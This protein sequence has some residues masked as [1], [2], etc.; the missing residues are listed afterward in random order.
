M[1]SKTDKRLLSKLIAATLMGTV[2]LS[3]YSVSAAAPAESLPL[4]EG[5]SATHESVAIGTNAQAT[6]SSNA[7]GI[8]AKASGSS[9]VLGNGAQAVAGGVAIGKEAVAGIGKEGSN[10]IIVGGVAVGQS[11][12]AALGGIA[13]GSS[14]TTKNISDVVIGSN[15]K[16][17]GAGSTIIGYGTEGN[18]S[19]VVVGT[20]SKAG[21]NAL[22]I[23]YEAEASQFAATA[24]GSQSK[25][26]AM[27]GV[28]LGS[29][30][31]ADTA[32][33]KTG[34]LANKTQ[35]A[36]VAKSVYT[37]TNGAVS[38]G[39]TN[40]ITRQ[41]TNVA[42]GTEDTDV[43]NVRQLKDLDLAVDNK[44]STQLSAVNTQLDGKLDADALQY[45]S[46]K[47]TET[48]TGSNEDNLGANGANS[49]A[50]GPKA[51]A[52]YTADVAMGLNAN[53][54]GFYSIALGRDSETT[55]SSS[56]AVGD[57]A[58][59]KTN[60][61][62]AIG[63]KAITNSIGSIS[64]GKDATTATDSMAAMA[65]GYET[66][67]TGV[68][69][70]AMGAQAKA[71]SK[72]AT[73]VGFDAV[74]Q[75]ASNGSGRTGNNAVAMG[76]SSKVDGG[77][78]GIAI[79]NNANVIDTNQATVVGTG[80]MV[81]ALP[82]NSGDSVV[83][84]DGSSGTKTITKGDDGTY[85]VVP[86]K[87]S[88][89][90][91]KQ[92]N[93]NAYGATALGSRATAHNLG[94][95]AA[96]LYA[97]AIGD[98]SVAIGN[99]SMTLADSATAVGASATATAED[100]MVLGGYTNANIDTAVALGSYAKT[101]RAA[102]EQVGYNPATN[103]ASTEDD[104][105]WKSTLGAVSVGNSTAGKTRQ[106]TNV[107]AGFA[108]TDAVN[109]AQLKN[110]SLKVTGDNLKTDATAI[111][112]VNLASQQ[113]AINGDSN[114][115][116]TVAKDGQS[117]NLAL[118]K[119]VT[120]KLGAVQYFS[121]NSTEA[122]NKDNKG[123]TKTGAIAIGA[124]AGATNWYDIAIGNNARSS[125]SW[126]IALGS[127]A[128]V[129]GT[130]ATAIGYG[131]Q[132]TNDQTIALGYMANASGQ[133]ATA[134]GRE[135][136]AAGGVSIALGTQTHANADDSV[137]IGRKSS[138][139]S[140]GV[141]SI[142]I[143]QE[144]YIGKK[145]E[146]GGTPAEGVLDHSLS[147]VDNDTSSGKE[148]Q[149][150]MNSIAIGSTA[151]SYGYQNTVLGVG[152]EAH[153]T[154]DV[155][156]GVLAKA[157]GH[158]ATA[159]GKQAN[160]NGLEATALGHWARA[161]GDNA[162]A[163]G[164]YAITSTLDGTGEVKN[165]IAIGK[166]ARV[167]SNNSVALGQNSL[168]FVPTDLKTKAYLSE[169]EFAAENGVISVG[170]AEYTVGDVSV[171]ENRR[172][173]T[174]VAGG[175]DDYDAVNVKQLKAAKVE[176]IAG[177]NVTVDTD[178]TAGYT[179]YTVNSV[180]TDTK[181]VDGTAI[182]N[183]NG[184]GAIT[185]NTEQNGTKGKVS[186]I[187]LHDKYITGASLTG[188]T[189]TINR[190]DGENFTVD[191]IATKDDVTTAVGDSSWTLG[192]AKVPSITT[193]GDSEATA[194][195][196]PTEIKNGNTVTLRAERGI[197]LSQD[198]SNIDIGLKYID[199]DPAVDAQPLGVSDA[200][201]S[202]AATLAVGQNS[203]ADGHQ[204]TAVGFSSHA[205]EYSLAVGSRA[206]A[207]AARSLA[208]GYNTS[209]GVF[210]VAAGSQAKA[211]GQQSIAV[212]TYTQTNGVNSIGIGMSA[213]K[214]GATSDSPSDFEIK[215]NSD[216]AIA[217][218]RGTYVGLKAKKATAIGV[219]SKIMG[220]T[221][222]TSN[223]AVLLGTSSSITEGQSSLLLGN[224]AS[225]N[226]SQNAVGVGSQSSIKNSMAG[227]AVGYLAIA[228]DAEQG[229]AIGGGSI[230]SAKQ[231]TAVG[232]SSEVSAAQGVAI[233]YKSN[234]GVAHGVALGTYSQAT[235]ANNYMGYNP[236][237]GT[238]MENDEAAI[239]KVLG[240]EADLEAYNATMQNSDPK[241][242][243]YLEAK[244]N[245]EILLSAYKSGMSAVSVG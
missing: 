26:T 208:L 129:S 124:K 38:V 216:R 202:G 97:T 187:G 198:G 222:N 157:K 71:L 200:K 79:G 195:G 48:G 75:N 12:N 42:A 217:I 61:T 197:K 30:T 227:T 145:T 151:K 14:A 43:V 70:T 131:A 31:V 18:R 186:V 20:N 24:L 65:I 210:G 10:E 118:S 8:G 19:S 13:I 127:D 108:D 84:T 56:V 106:I 136:N 226:K 152:A 229:T 67:A 91:L 93:G 15:S 231:A 7:I 4:G 155:A 90:S 161:Y 241:S 17:N 59:S 180:D 64:I 153:D 128:N 36:N 172:R 239:A 74:I 69:A 142:A 3:M 176:V 95:V 149:E 98:T 163:I 244:T 103:A 139:A 146:Q 177:G 243:E 148:N 107:A 212:G 205:G 102:G 183:D 57:G 190:N 22:S 55:G 224:K 206:D 87:D 218:G 130:T 2:G 138:V 143:G 132:S 27:Q 50:I 113:L 238:V 223:N 46:I 11:A 245:K 119:T 211:T 51:V 104:A 228:K 166:Q 29:S 141:N 45:V 168:A 41:I 150:Y 53:A 169:E 60:E 63:K 32:S 9:S 34:Y 88:V 220:G 160:A 47:S 242:Q 214:E 111:G 16:N 120:D 28:A 83:I 76:V 203:I 44:I 225:I 156:I 230:V 72:S 171:A 221:T 188:N 235:R 40:E 112:N 185:L 140:Q 25:V 123:A 215:T 204:G 164:S 192:V 78:G 82:E 162:I 179:K 85:T 80:A 89:E 184:T 181:I 99:N 182:Y 115:T 167:A 96:G 21:L 240:R 154:N 196:T 58:K 126:S 1:K 109:V 170:N 173:I 232:G 37:S 49:I 52:K 23:G 175:A 193:V 135:A 234:A 66:N 233:G 236:L 209:A 165:G 201:A 68:A 100:S 174:N 73:A 33:G 137:A 62:V 54:H 144:A 105:T 35:T 199:V 133:Q 81:S 125:G 178:T 86:T 92:R 121:V 134:I 77:N 5:S 39:K 207:S 114:I 191:N 110:V 189:L 194:V 116:T 122:S 158:Y 219:G 159:M 94:A 237:T 6:T 117:V 147:I 213:K 101:D